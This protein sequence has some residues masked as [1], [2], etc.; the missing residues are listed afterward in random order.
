M[1][2]VFCVHVRERELSHSLTCSLSLS[3]ALSLSH[4]HCCHPPIPT[5]N[6]PPWLLCLRRWHN[7]RDWSYLLSC[8]MGGVCVCVWG[9]SFSISVSGL[10]V[11]FLSPHLRAGLGVS[12]PSIRP[13]VPVALYLSLFSL[14]LPSRRV[15]AI[16]GLSGVGFCSPAAASSP[17]GPCK[18]RLLLPQGPQASAALPPN[19]FAVTL[20]AIGP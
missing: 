17:H 7:G 11:C 9:G 3:L 6:Q 5:V 13:S 16:V 20:S 4:P 10:S 2:C 8:V 14:C 12:P 1:L 18:T 19:K 15:E